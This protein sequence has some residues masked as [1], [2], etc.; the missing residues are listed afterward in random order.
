MNDEPDQV[1]YDSKGRIYV[2]GKKRMRSVTSILNLVKGDQPWMK[3]A[4]KSHLKRNPGYG[5][6]DYCNDA[7]MVG[8]YLHWR[9]GAEL[10]KE[11]NLPDPEFEPTRPLPDVIYKAKDNEMHSRRDDFQVMMSYWYD[12]KRICKPTIFST[13]LERFVWHSTGFAG[14]L[15]SIMN[16]DVEA[17]HDNVG[18]FM[19]HFD[20]L[21][22]NGSPKEGENW[23]VDFKSSKAVYESYPAQCW[24]YK[25]A[26]EE[27]T[28][29]KI[30]RLA[31]LR[32]NGETGWEFKE[33]PP[34]PATWNKAMRIA[35]KEGFIR[36]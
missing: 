32:M 6:R 5:W 8:T 36:V 33:V 15:D 3:F 1:T 13:G 25:I 4:E 16:L 17:F 18:G 28:G 9:I 7:M 21:D 20:F 24:A 35:R 30:H 19:Q 10:A 14:R 29:T 22:E 23:L 27:R 12:F 34:D 2:I 31:I 11:N 26:W